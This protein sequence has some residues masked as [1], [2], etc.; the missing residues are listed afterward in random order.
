MEKL[1]KVNHMEKDWDMVKLNMEKFGHMIGHMV[2]V[3]LQRME[4]HNMLAD[5]KDKTVVAVDTRVGMT[6]V[7]IRH[8]LHNS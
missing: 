6:V 1:H 2:E 8:I 5:S 7:D 4:C 3:L